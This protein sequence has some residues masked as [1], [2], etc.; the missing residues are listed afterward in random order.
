M[1]PSRSRKSA[2]FTRASGNAS[3]AA[4][5]RRARRPPA[6]GDV[7]ALEDAP[8]LEDAHVLGQEPVAMCRPAADGIADAVEHARA[9]RRAAVD[10]AHDQVLVVEIV[11]LAAKE[12]GEGAHGDRNRDYS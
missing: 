7:V 11:L 4:R 9:G 1:T 3:A 12:R 2:R 10:L 6:A 5:R 8:R